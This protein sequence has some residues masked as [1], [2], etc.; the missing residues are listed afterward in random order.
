LKDQYVGDVN[1]FRKYVLLRRLSDGGKTKIGIWWML[2]PPDGRTDGNRLAYLKRPQQWRHHDPEVFGL[3]ATLTSDPDRRRVAEIERSGLLPGATFLT[4]ALCDDAEE[5]EGLIVGALTRFKTCELIF[6]DPD[7]GFEVP[8]VPRGRKRSSK[9]VYF[10]DV[11]RLY[12]A[13]FSVLVYQHFPPEPRDLVTSR[14]L[15]K[16]AGRLPDANLLCVKSPEVAYFLAAQPRQKDIAR[17]FLEPGG[18]WEIVRDKAPIPLPKMSRGSSLRGKPS[19]RRVRPKE[20]T[21]MV[22]RLD[23][24]ECQVQRGERWE[25]IGI[26][27][28]LSLA[29]RSTIRCPE[30][31]QRVSA[32]KR[33]VNGGRA[34]F[35][36]RSDDGTCRRA[37]KYWRS[38][39]GSQA[40]TT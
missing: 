35:E 26:A 9:Y 33:S 29:D 15:G 36:H 13:G 5:R 25:T 37:G 2:T 17:R 14:I 22:T 23:N 39:G 19:G 27:E 28:A 18:L 24:V 11:E 16:L 40:R 8:S 7:N 31:H 30:C 34:H 20:A 3:L 38:R 12:R 4:D 6:L 1:D 21:T 32:H 10:D